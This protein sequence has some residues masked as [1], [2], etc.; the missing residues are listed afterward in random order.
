MAQGGTGDDRAAAADLST[1]LHVF[2]V[3]ATTTS[4][5]GEDG[6]QTDLVLIDLT[7]VRAGEVESETLAMRAEHWDGL[8]RAVLA[9]VGQPVEEDRERRWSRFTG[10]LECCIAALDPD[11]FVVLNTP[12]GR[13]VQLMVQEDEVRAETVSNQYLPELHRLP[14]EE[15]DTLGELHWNP[16]T[17]RLSE[18]ADHHGG[19]PNHW[20]DFDEDTPI[21]VMASLLVATLRLVHG[22]VE[23]EDLTYQAADLDGRRIVIPTLGLSR[24][25]EQL[26]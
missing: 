2:G 10:R 17:H 25:R 7:G 21:D 4:V 26:T 16:P 5:D 15:L 19:S 12:L 18:D 6:N 14:F 9:A 23:P 11:E 24:T 3:E 8:H 1:S 20:V 13:F 22:V